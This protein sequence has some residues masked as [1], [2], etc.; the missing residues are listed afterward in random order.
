MTQT[1]P[2]ARAA[3]GPTTGPT[4]VHLVPHTHW[5]REWY[6]PFQRFRIRLVDLLDEVL[7]RAEADERFHF[8]L[9][10]QM[11]AVDDYLEVRPEQ[12][13]RIAALVRAGRLA[14]G[15]WQI[16]LDEFLVSGENIVRNLELGWARAEELGGAMPVGYLP[17]EFGHCAQMPQILA[18]AGLAHACLWRGVP[19][20]VDGHAF[21]WTAPDGSTVR[22][23]YL[24]A[25]YG[26]A[27]ALFADP[28]RFTERATALAAT[29]RPLFG[30]EPVLGMYGTDHSAPVASLVHLVAGLADSGAPVRMRIT[31]LAE[32]IA[33]RDADPA[34]LVE[35]RGELRSHA[36]ANILP[37]VLSVRPHLKQ[38]M[39]RAERMVERYAEP[40]AA[41]WSPDWPARFLDMAWWR[42]VD[43]SGHDSVTGC[44][45]DE[46]AVQVYARITEAEHLGQAVRD[47]VLAGITGAVGRDAVVVANPS[48][49]E[50]TDLVSLDL[51]VP[52]DGGATALE[53]P[54]GSRV[55]AQVER[56]TS[57]PLHEEQVDV[58]ALPTFFARIHGRE[59]FG[60]EIVDWRLDRER[61]L[62]EFDL[63]RHG[64]AAPFDEDA[65]R[66]AV[67]S[68]AG[69]APWTVRMR[70]RESHVLTGLVRVPALGR[71]AVRAVASDEPVPFGTNGLPEPVRT[72]DAA[73]G[74]GPTLDNGLVRVTAHTDGTL[75]VTAA[76]GTV[77]D[78][79]GRIVDGGDRGDTYNYGPPATDPPLD[80]PTAVTVGRPEGGAVRAAFTV[81]RAYAWPAG[82]DWN[83]DG[84][85]DARSA[86]T[87]PATVAMRV[88]LR[89]GEPFVRL[90][91]EIDNRSADHRVRLHV[92]TARPA[93]TS[94]A[95]G[96][97]AV[98]ERGTTAE[99]GRSGEHPLPTFPAHGFVDAGGAGLLLA[100][101]SEYEL[102]D[103]ELALTL[104]RCTGLMSRNVHPYRDE[105][106]GSELP[107]PQA[108]MVGTT[109]VALAVLPHAGDWCAAD[110]VG[111]A[112]RFRH[113]LH[114]TPGTGEPGAALTEQA[115]LRVTGAALTSLRR[116]GE[117]M[118]LRV[119][120]QSPVPT[121]A[122]VQGSF[123]AATTVDLL[124]RPGAPL[125]VTDG[126]V[127]LPLRPWEIA[128]IRL[129]G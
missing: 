19:A 48:P 17:D 109:T 99:G 101:A 3:A 28:D 116:R 102:L 79:V 47:R 90:G 9:D 8:T 43:A 59:L 45:V 50:R 7:D 114:A 105:P 76:D 6:E 95:E 44:G 55:P 70:T 1:E 88:E 24:A 73:P 98:V 32:Y 96:Q 117:A 127:V 113:P 41:L 128:T 80:A 10:G 4:T 62:L 63:A 89:A 86:A 12:R 14:V 29:L 33:G 54:D 16:L 61:R 120:A 37:G 38:A 122:V 35:V 93:A 52:A 64:G 67:R 78:G 40:F 22:V 23:E 104:L 103:G 75:A 77:L 91:L 124:G 119:V 15:P 97:F 69:S 100:Q 71:T 18:R 108:Q 56:R 49:V 125:S 92:P 84:D 57:A 121:E 111:A 39:A 58:A 115:G 46:T 21:A 126:R 42:L 20:A 34:G 60:S 72:A 106:A 31:T 53:L 87:E 25:G 51:E 129:E 94:H 65:L 81:E 26:N 82:M 30:T 36:G 27:A 118:E 112:E 83:T 74:A 2:A 123:A 107:T 11:A 68:A 110:L 5:D 13:D 85:R 66:A